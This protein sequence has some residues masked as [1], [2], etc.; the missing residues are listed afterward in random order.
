MALKRYDEARAVFADQSAIYQRTGRKRDKSWAFTVYNLGKI[1]YDTKH[2]DAAIR[3][4]AEALALFEAFG[5]KDH[6]DIDGTLN[7]IA[8]CHVIMQRWALALN[9]LDRIAP[10]GRPQTRAVTRFTRGQAL[11]GLG[12]AQG[13][14]EARAARAEMAKLEVDPELIGEADA[15]LAH[16]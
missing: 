7:M 14:A 13:V 15:W 3:Q 4:F 1:E 8:A 6:D 2:Y 16:R 5:E 10:G 12:N 11:A 9:T